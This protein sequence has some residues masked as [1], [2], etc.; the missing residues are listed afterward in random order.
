MEF[1]W[2]DANLLHIA[3]HNVSQDEAEQVCESDTVA[4]DQYDVSGE[5]RL[6]EVGLTRAG[7]VLKVISVDRGDKTRV[8]TAYDAAAPEIRSFFQSKLLP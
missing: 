7:R 2:D 8:V 6:A 3:L 5:D 4:L 1:D